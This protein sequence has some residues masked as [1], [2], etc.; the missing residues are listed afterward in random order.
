M[1]KTNT[2][3]NTK[4]KTPSN[5]PCSTCFQSCEDL[6][7]GDAKGKWSLAVKPC[8]PEL[9]GLAVEKVPLVTREPPRIMPTDPTDARCFWDRG[10]SLVRL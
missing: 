2:K 9:E 8:F 10:E 1:K 4:T 3:I 6:L 5:K 7:S